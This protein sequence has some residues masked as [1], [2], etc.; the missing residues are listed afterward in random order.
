MRLPHSPTSF[1]AIFS[2]LW[3]WHKRAMNHS[4]CSDRHRQFLNHIRWETPL[5]NTDMPMR[6][7][8]EDGTLAWQ[9]QWETHSC[10]HCILHCRRATY[11]SKIEG[12]FIREKS[13]FLGCRIDCW[14]KQATLFNIVVLLSSW[15]NSTHI[16]HAYQFVFLR[17]CSRDK[18][19]G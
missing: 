11:C 19:F 6:K 15:W 3:P 1:C 7:L 8:V 2:R 12:K 14:C 18:N 9:Q 10:N 4:P 13:E 5:P 17:T 16:N